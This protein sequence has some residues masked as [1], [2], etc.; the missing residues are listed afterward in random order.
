MCTQIIVSFYKAMQGHPVHLWDAL[1][2][3]LRASYRV[4]NAA[5]E[6][7]AACSIAFDAQGQRLFAGLNNR[8]CIFDVA[9]PGR[10][11]KN[12]VPH[13]RASPGL[14]GNLLTVL[15]SRFLLSF[16]PCYDASVSFVQV[17]TNWKPASGNLF[18]P[19]TFWR[20]PWQLCMQPLHGRLSLI[21]VGLLCGCGSR[22]GV[23]LLGPCT[24]GIISCMACNPDR[25]A[26]LA[27]GSYLGDT[28]ILDEN[29]GDLLYVLQGQKG[30]ITQVPFSLCTYTL[31]SSRLSCNP[32]C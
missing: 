1:S 6:V 3:E 13:S 11:C 21:D 18:L 30:G 4:Y 26:M 17:H 10:Y 8:L 28:G 29:T 16:F 2:G 15:S 12:I 22:H 25:S 20:E 27:A 23:F 19:C 24:A 7:T 9:R 5:D 31:L 14:Q 32:S